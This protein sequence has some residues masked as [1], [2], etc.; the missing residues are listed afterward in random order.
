LE[1]VKGSDRTKAR[2]AQTALV[3]LLLRIASDLGMASPPGGE[4][5]AALQPFLAVRSRL[6]DRFQGI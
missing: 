2:R 6:D 4:A 1:F 3:T 5:I